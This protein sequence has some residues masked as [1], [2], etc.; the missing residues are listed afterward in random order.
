MGELAVMLMTMM[1]RVG[2][3]LAVVTMPA[4]RMMTICICQRLQDRP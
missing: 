2:A 4:G 3:Q 1:L